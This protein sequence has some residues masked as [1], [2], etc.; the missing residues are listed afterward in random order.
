VLAAAAR[1]AL[2]ATGL[3]DDTTLALAERVLKMFDAKDWLT[4]GYLAVHSSNA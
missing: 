4:L 2:E 1:P 3:F